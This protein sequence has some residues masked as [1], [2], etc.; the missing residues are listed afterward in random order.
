MMKKKI[1]IGVTGFRGRLGSALVQL[2]C[3]PLD[4]NI[5]NP[6]TILEA[7]RKAHLTSSDTIIHCAAFTD[8]DACELQYRQ[9]MDANILGTYNVRAYF[10]GRIIYISTDY[11]FNGKKGQYS[12][13]DVPSPICSYGR[14][15]YLGELVFKDY[16]LPGDI[17]VRT[18]MLY[19]GKKPDFV[20]SVLHKLSLNAPFEVTTSLHGNPTYVR[21]LAQALIVLCNYKLPKKINIVN[22]AG[23]TLLS[24]YEFAVIIAN[25]FGLDSNL[26]IPT[27]KYPGIATR[28]RNCGFDLRLAQIL[29]L[30]LRSAVEGLQEYQKD[31]QQV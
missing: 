1:N 4:C 18:T 15:K 28:P 6:P 31:M 17:I 14:T 26:I 23:T 7:I 16:G 29:D 20:S 10:D 8:V 22:I 19:G 2:G 13:H 27:K 11:I 24:R 30:P 3:I 21:H 5:N 9:A 12:E 25:V